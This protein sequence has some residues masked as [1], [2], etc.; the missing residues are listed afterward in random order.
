MQLNDHSLRQLD[1]AY[2]ER[3]EEATLRALS[4]KL[5]EDLKEAR[6]RLNQ[7]PRN[8]S[9]P[10]SSEAPWEKPKEGPAAD[11]EGDEAAGEFEA[12]GEDTGAVG[13]RS[14]D[15]GKPSP[16]AVD[17]PPPG[18]AGK[19]AGTPGHG[20]MAPERIDDIQTHAPTHCAVCD[21]SLEG[22]MLSTYTGYYE[23]DF[24]RTEGEWRIRYTLHHWQE[25]VCACGHHTQAQPPR[26]E[27]DGVEIGGFR[28]IGPGLATLIVALS[29]RYR[30]SRVRVRE[31][32]GD[33]LGVWL[34]V[35]A[36]HR[37]IEEAGV[38]VAP[39][40]AELID[41][42]LQS[43]LLKADETPWPEQGAKRE[44]LWL[45]VFTSAY[46]TLYYVSYR[47]QELVRNLLAGYTGVLMS[48]GWQ[49][50]RWLD[51]RLRCWAHLKRKGIGLTE[52]LNVEAQGFGQDVLTLWHALRE[53]VRQAREGPADSIREAFETRL[54][55]FRSRCEAMRAS[56]HKKTRELAG[57]FLN[58]WDAI[59]A[60]LD[61]PLWPLTNNDAERALRHW[62]I[63]RKLTHGTRT[64]RGSRGLALLASVTDTCRQRGHSPWVY[65]QTAI[66]RR[67]QNLALLPLP[68]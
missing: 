28:L 42:V 44:S 48:D 27:E 18:R 66:T 45:W 14:E 24:E 37:A 55:A 26:R 33:W 43:G 13:D 63:L 64:A 60:V 47:G 6:E 62:V 5:L 32:L 38:V 54:S 58:D 39:A 4:V 23:V 67:R 16:K 22:R 2:L 1:A 10:P 61:H 15:S 52:S 41:A 17:H 50:Y 11:E 36:I 8:S 53:A 59:F 29:L 31:F 21:L 25:A 49:A 7:N 3:L 20:R 35:G 56:P 30:L 46:V 19:V 12:E 51:K 40:E 34:S 9:R 65:L 68:A 57:E